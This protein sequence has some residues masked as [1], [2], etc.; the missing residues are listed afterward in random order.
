[1]RP[2]KIAFTIVSFLA[3]SCGADSQEEEK[4]EEP[5][6]VEQKITDTTF[7]L[8]DIYTFSEE[9]GPVGVFDIPEMLVLSILDSAAS[10]DVGTVMNKNYVTLGEEVTSI[11][12]EINGPIG[13][14]NYNNDPKNFTFENIVFIKRMPKVQPAKSKLVVL[15]ASKM[16]VF[17]FYGPYQSLFAAYDKIRRYCEKQDLLQS[18]PMREFYLTDPEKEK[19]QQKWLTRIMLPVISMHKK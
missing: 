15:E 5:A 16:L 19:D 7:F 18:G 4:K 6:A 13:M 12:A 1:M 3:V 17:N 10:N 9:G 2:F 14:I 8:N 11:G